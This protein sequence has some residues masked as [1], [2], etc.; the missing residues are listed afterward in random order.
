MASEHE[1]ETAPA[2]DLLWRALCY[3]AGELGPDDVE[4]FE[5]RLDRDQDA[6]EAVARAVELAGAVAALPPGRPGDAALPMP[7]RRRLAALAAV[8]SL[9]AAACL[10]GLLVGPRGTIPDAVPGTAAANAPSPTVTLA[11][12]SLRL[13]VEDEPKADDGLP[14]W[15][16]V[17]AA[18]EPEVAPVAGS[19]PDGASEDGLSPW[20]L[21]AAT[22]ARGSAPPADGPAP[23]S[24]E[25]L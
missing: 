10:G 15:N 19:E 14:A 23:S 12:S 4:A 8:A 6:R 11:W 21:E 20:L 18:S 5:A 7:R 16:G 1:H 25:E 24:S 9:A 3:V 17:A 22:L 13:E 2:D